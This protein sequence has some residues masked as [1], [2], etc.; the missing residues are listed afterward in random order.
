MES[1]ILALARGDENLAT[2]AIWK[3]P[4]L[5]EKT[6]ERYAVEVR[7]EVIGFHRCPKGREGEWSKFRVIKPAKNLKTLIANF[8]YVKLLQHMTEKMPLAVRVYNAVATKTKDPL[9]FPPR[10]ELAPLIVQNASAFHHYRSG[11]RMYLPQAFLAI[12]TAWPAHAG[13]QVS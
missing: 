7:E 1:L 10:L 12:S 6:V 13:K 8:N 2:T 3:H 9:E 11:G 4:G 5:R